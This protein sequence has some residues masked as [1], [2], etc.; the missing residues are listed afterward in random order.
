MSVEGGNQGHASR[1]VKWG[2]LGI[3]GWRFGDDVDIW[4]V[5]FKMGSGEGCGGV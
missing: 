4:V 1:T 2:M 3:F 5:V